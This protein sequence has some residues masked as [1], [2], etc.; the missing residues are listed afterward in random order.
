VHEHACSTADAMTNLIVEYLATGE[1]VS[2]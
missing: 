2:K 1:K